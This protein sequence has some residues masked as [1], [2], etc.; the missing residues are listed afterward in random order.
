[1]IKTKA[2]TKGLQVFNYEAQEVRTF[3]IEGKPWFVAKDVCDILGLTNPTKALMR[4]DADE[5]SNLKLGRQG[6]TNIVNEYGLYSLILSSRKPE[7]KAFKRWITHEVI[8]SIRKDG[9][10]MT[11]QVAQSVL[12]NPT[13]FL[14]HAVLVADKEIQRLNSVINQQVP[15][16]E[17]YE[18]YLDCNKTHSFTDIGKLVGLTATDIINFLTAKGILMRNIKK[19]AYPTKAWLDSEYFVVKT[20]KNYIHTRVTPTGFDWLVQILQMKRRKQND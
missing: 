20:H 9:M 10:Y 14:A 12:D 8:P 5:R 2:N 4:L 11:S 15:K 18:E 7:A 1:M 6:E 19:E 13:G 3:T 17:M 16:V